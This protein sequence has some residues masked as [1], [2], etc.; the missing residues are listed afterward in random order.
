MYNVQ[1]HS[2]QEILPLI[3][4]THHNWKIYKKYINIM[5]PIKNITKLSLNC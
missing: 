1:L 4:I 2:K 5:S 3:L